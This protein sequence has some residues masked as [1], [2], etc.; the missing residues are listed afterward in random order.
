MYLPRRLS[1]HSYSDSSE[2]KPSI[3]VNWFKGNS[4]DRTE[5]AGGTQVRSCGL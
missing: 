2:I 3:N 5:M 1:L 4:G